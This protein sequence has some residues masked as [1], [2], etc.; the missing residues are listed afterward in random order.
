MSSAEQGPRGP[1]SANDGR[2]LA[3]HSQLLALSGT[4][5]PD[6]CTAGSAI[7]VQHRGRSRHSQAR[8]GKRTAS[9]GVHVGHA[10]VGDWLPRPVTVRVATLIVHVSLWGSRPIRRFSL[11]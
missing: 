11:T 8:F 1:H 9:A 5:G 2:S 3:I 10:R 6:S 4:D 7:G